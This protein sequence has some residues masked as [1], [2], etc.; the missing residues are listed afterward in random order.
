MARWIE[1]AGALSNACC[2]CI[3][4]WHCTY[5][6]G[7]ARAALEALLHVRDDGLGLSKGGRVGRPPG[8][9]AVTSR[10]SAQNV[11]RHAAVWLERCA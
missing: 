5:G 9:S 6:H 1:G 3:P 10:A 8:G 2:S 11:R 7:Y 4:T